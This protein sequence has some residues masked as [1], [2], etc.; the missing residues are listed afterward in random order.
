MRALATVGFVSVC[1]T[2]AD[3]LFGASVA[4]RDLPPG[5]CWG[6]ATTYAYWVFK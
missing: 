2:I 6:A 3:I 5:K 1:L 4:L